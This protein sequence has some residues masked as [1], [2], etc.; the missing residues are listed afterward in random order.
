MTPGARAQGRLRLA[1]QWA[2]AAVA[3]LVIVASAL[4][5]DRL[6]STDRVAMAP[7]PAPA[8]I[9]TTGTATSPGLNVTPRPSDAAEPTLVPESVDR[10][11]IVDLAVAAGGWSGATGSMGGGA[12]VVN[13]SNGPCRLA[14]VPAVEL[15]ADDGRV[16]A[17]GG[18]ARSGPAVILAPG[19]VAGVITVWRNWCESSR[20]RALALRLELLDVEGGFSA[21]VANW[22]GTGS[23]GSAP[24][25]DM[26]SAP[27]TISVPQPFAIPFADPAAGMVEPCTS[28]DLTAWLGVWGP[29]A[30]TDYSNVVILNRAGVHCRLATSPPLELRDAAGTLLATAEPGADASSA[31]D[32]GP[33]LAAIATIGLAD[34][35][36]PAPRLPLQLELRI[37]TGRVAVLPTSEHSVIGIPSCNSAPA[38]PPPTFFYDASFAVP[39]PSGG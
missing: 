27:S 21:P 4:A 9:A 28:E 16:I 30:G 7:S 10:C 31:L 26:P 6:A 19:G 23:G 1:R 11:A 8:A 33:G 20:P 29:A 39:G 35:C 32:L 2:T 3:L 38:S 34:W 22:K 25:C 15:L 36:G 14:G 18:P 17:T 24:R 13:V 5:V 12:T 37:G